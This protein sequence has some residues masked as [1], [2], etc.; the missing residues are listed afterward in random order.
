MECLVDEELVTSRQMD[1]EEE[2]QWFPGQREIGDKWR[3]S[4]IRSGFSAV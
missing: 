2:D 3:P 4:G 1:L